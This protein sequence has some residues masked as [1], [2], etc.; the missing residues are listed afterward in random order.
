MLWYHCEFVNWTSVAVDNVNAWHD[1]RWLK[2]NNLETNHTTG[3]SDERTINPTTSIIYYSVNCKIILIKTITITISILGLTSW[4]YGHMQQTI[5]IY[6]VFLENDCNKYYNFYKLRVPFMS[7]I[8][9][10]PSCFIALSTFSCRMININLVI[11]KQIVKI[12]Y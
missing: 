6:S 10:K 2:T 9:N 12:S 11:T 4:W 3:S 1:K 8:H 5:N 7:K